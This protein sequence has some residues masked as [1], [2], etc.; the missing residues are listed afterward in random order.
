MYDG[1][2]LIICLIAIISMIQNYG[3]QFSLIF[4]YEFPLEFN[5][6]KVSFCLVNVEKIKRY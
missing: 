1:F 3:D 6:K 5:K 4:C 2:N